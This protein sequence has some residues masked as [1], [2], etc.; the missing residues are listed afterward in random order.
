LTEHLSTGQPSTG[1]P[2]ILVERRDHTLLITIN[3]PAAMNA[4]NR[5]VSSGI[6]RALELAEGDRDIRAVVLTGAGDRAF[7]AGA[8]L[9][10]VARGEPLIDPQEASWGFAGYVRHP[11]SKPTIA[12]VNGLALGGGAEIALAS[13]LVVAAERATFG[14]PEVRRGLVAAAGG[15]L[16]L[17]AQLP[18]K[19]AME[20]ILTGEPIGARAAARWGLA[21]RVVPDGAVVEAAL[22]LAGRIGQNAPLAVQ[23][24]KRIATGIVAGGIPAEEE[25]WRL[26]FA[27]VDLVKRS[28]DAR[29]GPSAFAQKREP[30]WQG[31]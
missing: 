20:M 5:E 3:R 17:P 26:N 19:I 13:D 24:S 6:G 22:E 8:D 12:A 28:A 18:R 16:R 23:A 2:A 14:L 30:R 25:H 11:I 7:S 4:I 27:E 9:K 15:V 10:A 31:R 29:E 1:Q 21:N